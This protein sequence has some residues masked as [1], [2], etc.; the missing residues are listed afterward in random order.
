MNFVK[1]SYCSRFY[2][3]FLKEIFISKYTERTENNLNKVYNIFQI[4]GGD[5]EHWKIM[6]GSHNQPP[7]LIKTFNPQPTTLN[8]DLT[9]CPVRS[10]PD[11]LLD[12]ITLYL[13]IYIPTI[14]GP[15][16]T[17]I[18]GVVCL[19]FSSGWRSRG[20]SPCSVLLLPGLILIH[21]SNYY[22]NLVFADTHQ[23]EFHYILVK[24]GLGFSFIILSPLLIIA[25][26]EQI[27]IGVKKTF[28]STVLFAVQNKEKN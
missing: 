26:Q 18:I 16:I 11:N 19:P 12:K 2:S 7:D 22:I 17:F 15:F 6:R 10:R 13:S 4:F 23:N 14:L 8:T 9:F 20:I 27:R 28:K 24:Y 1:Y 5:D 25:T 3:R 21:L